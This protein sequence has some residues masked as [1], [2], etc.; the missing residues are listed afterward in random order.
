MT[1]SR[2]ALA[3]QNYFQHQK[4]LYELQVCWFKA[5]QSFCEFFPL[6]TA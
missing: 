2:P 4:F 6:A 5:A 3:L 1:D